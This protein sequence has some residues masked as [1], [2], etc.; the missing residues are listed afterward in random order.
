MELKGKVVVIT[1]GSKGFGRA[2]AE[3]L[4]KEKAKVVICSHHREDVEQVAKEI[5]ALG[6][7]ADVTKEDDLTSLAHKALEHYGAIDIWVNNAGIWMGGLAEESDMKEVSNMFEV[8]V[9]G[10][11][12]GS[13]VALRVMKEKNSGTIIN[14]LSRA[15]LDG[16]PGISLYA[17]SKWALNGFTKSIREEVKDNNISVLSVFPGGMKTSIF[18]RN[19]PGNW[20]DFMDTGKAATKVIDNLK[21][22][23][24][25]E[26]I[27]IKREDV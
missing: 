24:P 13:R 20:G 4:L 18:N 10:T 15:A 19:K 8:N 14:I 6:V 22:E 1:G 12:N 9:M 23:K 5:G 17:A 11:I 25:E 16:R 27:I 7:Y 21:L 2:L 3:Q 26:E